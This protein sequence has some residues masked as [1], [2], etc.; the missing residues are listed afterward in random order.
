M[1]TSNEICGL[2]VLVLNKRNGNGRI[3]TNESANTIIEQFD[4]NIKRIGTV[5]GEIEDY[6][7]NTITD[8]SKVTHMVKRIYIGGDYDDIVYADIEFLNAPLAE[9]AKTM[10][11]EEGAVLRPKSIGYVLDDTVEISEFITLELVRA[12]NDPY[13]NL[14]YVPKNYW[15][16][17]ED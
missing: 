10:L 2:P 13:A 11:F 17:V 3:Y 14:F 16:L 15:E 1:T 7:G 6:S 8:L 12:E 9:L 4:K 5:F